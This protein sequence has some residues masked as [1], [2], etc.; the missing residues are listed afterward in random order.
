LR[1]RS[2][3]GKSPVTMKPRWH[4]RSWSLLALLLLVVGCRTNLLPDYAGRI[5][6]THAQVRVPAVG[7]VSVSTGRQETKKQSLAQSIAKTAVGIAAV[8]VAY[9]AERKL[10]EAM[11]PERVARIVTR[12]VASGARSV[13]IPF[14]AG[15]EPTNTQ[16]V[17]EVRSYG[18]EAASDLTP[19]SARF[20]MYGYL[21]YI[22]ESKLIWEYS[23]YVNIPLSSVHVAS[24]R[25]STAGD[26][27]NIAAIANLDRRDIR[28][29]FGAATRTATQRFMSMLTNDY[30][31][32]LARYEAKHGAFAKPAPPAAPPPEEPAD[33]EDDDT[34]A[35][36]ADPAATPDAAPT[37]PP[38]EQDPNQI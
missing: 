4:L 1:R 18:I 29:L 3:S 2:I 26:I 14:V 6:S 12:E 8:N 19:A 9:N 15:G 27:S 34:P 28:R 36:P 7:T 31:V 38:P 35:P 37:L 23:V 16:L 32:G 5:V 20:H 24:V 21:T 22:P 17:V 10:Q 11:P 25:N 30:Q 33:D 13:G